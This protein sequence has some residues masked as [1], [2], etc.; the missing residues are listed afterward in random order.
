MENTVLKVD[1]AWEGTDGCNLDCSS[2]YDSGDWFNVKYQKNR[3]LLKTDTIVPC[4]P[5]TKSQ[6]KF[7]TFSQ[8]THY[9]LTDTIYY[10]PD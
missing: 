8:D 7:N 3:I 5:C 9:I 1:Y 10:S 2:E 6:N 4:K